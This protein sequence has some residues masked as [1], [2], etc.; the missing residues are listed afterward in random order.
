M[1]NVIRTIAASIA[2]EIH[3]VCATLFIKGSSIHH[4]EPSNLRAGSDCKLSQLRQW[5]LVRPDQRRR[6]ARTRPNA[7]PA[8]IRLKVQPARSV[9]SGLD[10]TCT[11]PARIA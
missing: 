10:R 2:T 5:G 6:A 1:M 8:N 4:V 7:P 9:D 11:R 3:V